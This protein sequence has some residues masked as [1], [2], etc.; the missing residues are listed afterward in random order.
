MKTWDRL[1]CIIASFV[2]AVFVWL[3]TERLR[4]FLHLMSD[5][6]GSPRYEWCTPITDFVF[7]TFAYWPYVVYVG[8]L[9]LIPA[10]FARPWCRKFR[11]GLIIYFIISGPVIYGLCLEGLYHS[12]MM[13]LET[14]GH[15]NEEIRALVQKNRQRLGDGNAT[16]QES[17][18][19]EEELI[20]KGLLPFEHTTNAPDAESKANPAAPSRPLK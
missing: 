17:R 7:K 18:I 6:L 12:E 14:W 2:P 9:L 16:V 10:M 15:N 3:S 1:I 5:Y 20:K 8:W 13:V 4:R 11:T 19:I